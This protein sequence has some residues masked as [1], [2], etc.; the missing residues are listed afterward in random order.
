MR[1]ATKRKLAVTTVLLLC[2][3]EQPKDTINSR[4]TCASH[5]TCYDWFSGEGVAA[6]S[7]KF[8]ADFHNAGSGMFGTGVV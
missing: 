6:K 3:N 4:A 8:P 1:R 2:D 5:G 7:R